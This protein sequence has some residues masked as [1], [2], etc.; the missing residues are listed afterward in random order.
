[1]VRVRPLPASLPKQGEVELAFTDYGIGIV[2]VERTRI[3]ERFFR[4][5]QVVADGFKGSGLEL[6]ICQSVVAAHGGRIWAADA[7]HGGPGTTMFI[8]LPQYVMPVAE[9]EW[10]GR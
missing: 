9:K 8:V 2:P 10:E 1:V 6:Y 7:I 4:V 3:F 5:S